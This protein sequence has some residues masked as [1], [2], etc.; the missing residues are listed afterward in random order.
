MSSAVVGV[1]KIR[2]IDANPPD[3]RICLLLIDAYIPGLRREFR[4]KE[5]GKCSIMGCATD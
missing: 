2:S 5:F 3:G 1:L 4:T